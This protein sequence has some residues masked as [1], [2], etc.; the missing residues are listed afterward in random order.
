MP[1]RKEYQIC[2]YNVTVDMYYFGL[3]H[4]Y[5]QPH[6]IIGDISFMFG[7]ATI[8]FILTIPAIVSCAFAQPVVL[9]D[10]LEIEHLFSAQFKPTNMVFVGTND[11]LVLDRDAGYVYR[12]LNG[13]MDPEP[14]FDA[15]VATIGYRGMLGVDVMKTGTNHTF[16]FLYYTESNG[17]DRDDEIEQGGF[18]PKGNRLYR[19]E[20]QNGKLV[21]PK[22]LLDLPVK[23][24]PRHTGGEVA[25]GPDKNIYLTIG[26]LDGTFKERFET[27][28]QNYK[29]TSTLDG[30]AGIL[31]VTPD[32]SPVG[33]GIL[34]NQ[35][36]IN[37]YFAYG[38]RN[39]FGLDWD[40]VTGNLWDTENGPHYG[41]EINLVEPGFNSGW[42]KVQGIWEPN[43][44]VMGKLSLRPD[45]LVDFRGNGKYSEPEF[46]WNVPVAPTAL[47]FFDSNKY[48]AEYENDLFVADANTGSI[49]HF[50]LNADR[51]GLQL[52]QPIK[53]KIANNI[54]E[55]KDIV[56]VKGLG[57]ITDM[58]IGPDGFLYILSSDDGIKLDRIV[59]K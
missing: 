38:V 48:G 9:D 7:R 10:N 37:L 40:P 56:F 45:G 5:Y 41:D 18:E 3:M 2:Q 6:T 35:Y 21:N 16:V 22:L 36:P 42:V 39:S 46:I 20:L 19:Y 11:I 24:G 12:I 49:Y 1:M 55:L 14:V 25:V 44:D 52:Q 30:R 57:R 43:F 50:E 8:V 51:T 17:K 15:N 23:P 53:D 59:A 33:S 32:G 27:M 47:K 29:N 4:Y 31:R 54:D 34:G 58:Q 28:A 13:I 26:D